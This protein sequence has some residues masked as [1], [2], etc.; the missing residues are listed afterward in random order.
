VIQ[1]GQVNDKIPTT[2]DIG[3]GPA[4]QAEPRLTVSVCRWLPSNDG[5]ECPSYK[6]FDTRLAGTVA[7]V[8]I[9]IYLIVVSVKK[10][11]LPWLS[12]TLGGFQ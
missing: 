7:S 11:L 2:R 5:K 9:A 12:E 3:C 6:V 10:R 1:K 8:S 4:R